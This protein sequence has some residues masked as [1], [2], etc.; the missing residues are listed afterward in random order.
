[1]NCELFE[2][3]PLTNE[4][5]KEDKS[6][7]KYGPYFRWKILSNQS[8]ICKST[9]VKSLFVVLLSTTMF[10]PLILFKS[11]KD[12]QTLTHFRLKT[13]SLHVRSTFKKIKQKNYERK[14]LMVKALAVKLKNHVIC[15]VK[16]YCGA[17][18]PFFVCRK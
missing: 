8:K 6:K 16:I 11:L 15:L 14:K 2:R 4:L 12:F 7:F 18:F 9:Y 5:W 10:N 3:K 13:F 1:M 17:T